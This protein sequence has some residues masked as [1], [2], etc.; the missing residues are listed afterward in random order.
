MTPDAITALFAEAAA[1]FPPIAGNPSDDD[2]TAMREVLTPLLMD[3]PYDEEGPDPRHNLI[4]LIEPTLA[5]AAVW[6][7]ALPIPARPPAY[8]PAIAADATP[9]I[10]AR[11]E[12]AHAVVLKDY[13]TYEATE[14]AVAK[15]IRNAVD[16]IWYKDL[17]HARSFYNAVTAKTLLAHLDDNCGGLH[18]SELINL[19]TEMMGYY[20]EAEGIPEY[21]N[22]LEDA[23]RKL[24]RANLP[25]DDANLLAMASTAVLASQHYPRA[26]D[27][28]EALPAINKTW[29]EWKL[30]YRAA[31]IA[32]KRQLLAAGGGEPLHG[33]HAVSEVAQPLLTP[34]LYEQLEG[35][36]DNLANAATSEHTTLKQLVDANV[37][38]TTSVATLTTSVAALTAAYTLLAAGA[39]NTPAPAATARANTRATP[40][41]AAG[42]YCWTHGYRVSVGHNS[43]NCKKK[44]ENHKDAATR[45]NTMNGS[46]TN[47]GWEN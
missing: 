19:N 18:P 8:D 29:A 21:I 25:M 23:Q 14:R 27:D 11:M 46:N 31:H 36:L 3:I 4:G 22:A 12:A 43:A 15:F 37:T 35:Y 6:G 30:R 42:G 33:A 1:N 38:L 40:T 47:K 9:V 26:T 20:A 2:L 39:T 32:R 24:R 7:A 28:W 34:V 45:A 17:K 41:F 5:Y 13:A 16:E 44:A 10:R